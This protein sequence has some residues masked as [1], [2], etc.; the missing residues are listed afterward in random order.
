[1][2]E[3][4]IVATVRTPIGRAARGAFNDTAGVNLLHPLL[5]EVL[6]RASIEPGE[7]E[8]VAIG[9]GYPEG[10][11][12]GNIARA[13]AI[14]A[15]LPV[16]SAGLVVSRFCASGL[17]AVAYAARR[18]AFDQVPI[19]IGGG[20]ESI[21]L[22]GPNANRNRLRNPWLEE[23]KPG[24]YHTMIETADLVAERYGIS[25]ER[26]D[27]YAL[28][29]QRRT[30]TAQQANTFADEILAMEVEK[31]VTDKATGQTSKEKVRL[32][33]DEGNRPDT[34]LEGLSQLKPVREGQYVTA[35]N[36]S[37]LSDGASINLLMSAA[38]AV[39]RGVEPLAK[40]KGFASAGC[41]PEEMGIGPVFAV[42]RL[43]KRHGLSV[44]DIDLW[45]LN[46]AFASQAVYCIDKLALDH[47]KVNVN[48][49]AIAIGHP[50]GMSGS[51]MVGHAVLEGRRRG[52][53]YAVVTMCV[54]G[55]MGCAGLIEICEA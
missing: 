36:A 22:V 51:R 39:R 17:E 9:C 16:S 20:A 38:E 7:V 47:S 50:F 48:G 30:A 29:S 10:A 15:G 1:M 41:E 52:A 23:H 32:T 53:K 33:Q 45:E 4:V 40:F 24:I 11:T 31:V 13:A 14:R 49:G 54:A 46:E 12:G 19:A 28:E 44:D 37:Q 25:R 6:Q 27:E 5:P 3:A 2:E 34:T 42:P 35:G 26:Q 21:S 8:E 43:L 18:I 55:G